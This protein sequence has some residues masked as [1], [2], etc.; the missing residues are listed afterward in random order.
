[1]T[2]TLQADVFPA[3][4][5]VDYQTGESRTVH[6]ARV[7]V[8]ESPPRVL[9]FTDSSQ[10]PQVVFSDNV[11]SYQQPERPRKLRDLYTPETQTYHVTTAG[12]ALS[13]VKDGGCGCGSR[14]KG[15]NPFPA[16]TALAATSA[17]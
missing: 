9:V 1:M 17:Q 13:F 16:I 6:R 3:T 12:A 8:T 2:V 10:G 5:N 4:L 15:F 11:L 14:L 7:V